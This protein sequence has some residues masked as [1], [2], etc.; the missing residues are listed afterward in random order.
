MTTKAT[1]TVWGRDH[2]VVVLTPEA[3]QFREYLIVLACS[4]RPATR[5]PEPHEVVL[6]EA[7]GLD[8]P[9]L[10]KL[11]PILAVRLQDLE[12]RRGQVTAERRRQIGERM[13]R[14]FGLLA[15]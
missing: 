14:L 7:D 1:T 13:I 8:R 10:G 3:M 9:T 6:D 2:P 15:G 12:G 5:A 4:S 11:A